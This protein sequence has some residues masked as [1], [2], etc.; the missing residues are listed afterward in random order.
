M[1]I[2]KRAHKKLKYISIC[3]LFYDMQ[4]NFYQLKKAVCYIL[5]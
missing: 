3:V 1:N 2:K 5:L 4:F